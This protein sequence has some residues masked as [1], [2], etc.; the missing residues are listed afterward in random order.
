MQLIPSLIS[1][2]SFTPGARDVQVTPAMSVFGGQGGREHAVLDLDGSP[3]LED[4]V[5]ALFGSTPL[6]HAVT[7]AIPPLAKHARTAD[8][9]KN[10]SAVNGIKASRTP[11]AGRLVPLARNGKFPRSVGQAGPVG[12]R[13]IKGDKGDKG[14]AGPQ[15]PKGEP[16]ASGYQ[17]VGAQ[18]PVANET[19]KRTSAA[20][21]QGK[22]LL[23][24]GTYVSPIGEPAAVTESWPDSGRNQW[25]GAAR[26]YASST[27]TWSIYVF[28]VC[29][30][31]TT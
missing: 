14:D 13:G 2:A 17:V 25:T 28:A 4:L 24:G 21:P 1:Q 16:G 5:V 26:R 7:S 18:S 10:A 23:G 3:R 15:G 9:A 30:A 6:G 12:P 22:R 19:S 8:L 20:C 27:T 29:A 11:R 31:V